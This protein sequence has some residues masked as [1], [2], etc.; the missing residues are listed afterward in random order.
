MKKQVSEALHQKP[1]RTMNQLEDD[2]KSK[3]QNM[4]PEEIEQFSHIDAKYRNIER[5]KFETQLREI[6]GECIGPL[7]ER[8]IANNDRIGVIDKML[9]I[10]GQ[11]LTDLEVIYKNVEK[12]GGLNPKGDIHIGNGNQ[13][14]DPDLHKFNCKP[15]HIFDLI[16]NKIAENASISRKNEEDIRGVIKHMD[17]NFNQL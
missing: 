11:K 15:S 9:L 14:D 7:R 10:H 12:D 5:F 4:L 16:K 6:V 1:A 3:L 8:V 13:Y 2:A 17:A